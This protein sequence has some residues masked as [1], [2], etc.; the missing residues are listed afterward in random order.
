V[1]LDVIERERVQYRGDGAEL[2]SFLQRATSGIL[3]LLYAA[4]QLYPSPEFEHRGRVRRKPGPVKVGES[5]PCHF[6]QKTG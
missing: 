1:C 4:L 5:A 6:L 3:P 2:L